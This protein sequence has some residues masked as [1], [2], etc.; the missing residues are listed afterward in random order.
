MPINFPTSL[1]N[2]TN[3]ID[4]VDYPEAV[5]I[6]DLQDAVEALE[7]K[8]G[9]NSSGVTSS[10]DYKINNLNGSNITTG[11][12]A[13][14][15]LGSG[16]PSTATF[17]RGDGSW[18]TTSVVNQQTFNSSGTWTK[19]AAGSMAMIE[20]W[21][22]G[23]GGGATYQNSPA[24]GIGGGGGQYVRRI[25]RL[26]DLASS[27]PV[28]VGAGG[29]GRTGSN[30]P[31]TAG[32]NTTFGSHVTAYGGAGGPGDGS[33]FTTIDSF[34]LIRSGG[35]VMMT[36]LYGNQ[37][38]IIY[39]AAGLSGEGTW[40]GFH[41]SSGSDVSGPRV[42]NSVW[43]GG[44][45][46]NGRNGSAFLGGTS[47]Y[48]GAGGNGAQNSVSVATAGAQPGGGGGGGYGTGIYAPGANGG[49]GRCVVTVW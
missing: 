22:G 48:G 2:F 41:L 28:T 23:G 44:S 38:W 19:P 4:G 39:A 36:A 18:A 1:D 33:V 32:G 9:V 30:G 42:R 5:H 29:L 43:G 26:A 25:M 13:P 11:T 10:L 45:G 21:G 6:N 8:V 15:R 34:E 17:L 14:A 3:K 47:I 12:V 37:E 27:V 49:A 31:G 20:C 24:I 7:E 16:T 46:G 40:G 35:Q